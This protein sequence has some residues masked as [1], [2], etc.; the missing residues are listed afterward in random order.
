MRNYIN[1]LLVCLLAVQVAVAQQTVSG[2][3]TDESGIPL[4]GATVIVKGTSNGTATDFDGNYSISVGPNAVLEFS[5]IGYQTVEVTVGNQSNINVSLQPSN[6]LDEVVVTGFGEVSKKSFAGSAKVVEG[7]N[8]SQKSFTNVSQALAGEVAGVSVFNTSGQPGTVSTIR[9]RG[10]GSVNGSQAPLYIVDD[11]P[12]GGSLNDIN[13]NDIKSVTVLK[14]ASATSLYGAR[15]AN[16]VIVIT[17]KRG[18]DNG[19]SVNV[20][21]KSGTNYQG[22]GRY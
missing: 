6:Q 14:D 4:P 12:F 7:E 18:K 17:T 16:G 2:S 8:I 20:Q 5:F 13:P 1:F 10:F 21:V 15:G 19:N 3:V 9:I 22:I 11:A